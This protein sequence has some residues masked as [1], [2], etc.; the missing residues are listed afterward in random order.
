[1]FNTSFTPS[2]PHIFYVLHKV[3]TK[4]QNSDLERQYQSNLNKRMNLQV[5]SDL[6]P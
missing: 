4:T 6:G 5:S 2:F 1:M 3:G